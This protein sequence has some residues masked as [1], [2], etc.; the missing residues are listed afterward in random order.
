MTLTR[1]RRRGTTLAAALPSEGRATEPF[2][3]VVETHAWKA[4]PAADSGRALAS[5]PAKA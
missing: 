2:A 3:P 1:A 4:L 5:L